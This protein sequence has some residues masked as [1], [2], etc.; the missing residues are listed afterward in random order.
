[1]NQMEIEQMLADVVCKIQE[2]SG[3]ALVPVSRSTRPILDIPG[4]DSLNGVE[5]TIEAL[6]Y[7]HLDLEFNN[8]FLA[9]DKST[10]LTI[11]QAA[12]RLATCVSEQQKR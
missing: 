2:E 10:V 4:F 8:V 12:I 1:M 5:V 6:D 9:D 7:L 3:R 11:E